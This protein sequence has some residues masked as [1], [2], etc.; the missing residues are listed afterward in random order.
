MDNIYHNRPESSVNNGAPY[1]TEHQTNSLHTNSQTNAPSDEEIAKFFQQKF[2]EQ[3]TQANKTEPAYPPVQLARNRPAKRTKIIYKNWLLLLAGL[4]CLVVLVAVLTFIWGVVAYFLQ[5]DVDTAIWTPL[6]IFMGSLALATALITALSKGGTIYPIL[7]LWLIS[8]LG[9][10]LL[11]GTSDIQLLGAIGRL[12]LA[13]AVVIIVFTAVKIYY[14]NKIRY[15][16]KDYQKA[17]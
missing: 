14:L 6:L 8:S 11:A 1:N 17:A 12:A 16:Y 4:L 9:S 15:E 2:S 3:A 13:F 7:C 10:F 5:L